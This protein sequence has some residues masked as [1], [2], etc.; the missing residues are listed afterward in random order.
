MKNSFLYFLI[1]FI[2]NLS[3]V[4]QEIEINSNKIRYDDI[5]KVTIFEGNV[6]SVDEEGNKFFSEYT[7]YNKLTEI[8]E[9]KGDTKVIT[10]SGYEVFTSDV[11]FNNKENIIY[12][13]NKSNIVDKDGN[14]IS[15]QMFNYSILT[16]IFFSKG[17]IKIKDIN[18]N[19]YNFSEIY[20]DENKKKIIGSDIKAFL[21]DPNLAINA[22]NDPKFFANTMSSTENTNTYEKGVFT[23][24]K[25]RVDDKCP[26]WT[27]QSK[28][29]THDI[30]KKT[31]YYDNVVLKVYDF[32]IFWAP[33]FSH[34]DPTVKRR[35]G[36]LAPSLSNHSNLGSGI[37][38]PYFWNIAKDKDLTFTPKIYINENPL[39]LA[40][41]RQDFV[42]SFLIVDAGYTQGYKNN[43]LK[44][45]EGGRA[46]F[47]SN[48]TTKFV[49]EKEKRSS[50]DINIEKV[51]NDTYFKIYDVKSILVNKDKVV[52]ENKF[53][54]IYQNKDFF[55]GLAP[56]VYEDTTKLGHLRHE[57][58]LPLTVEKNIMANQKYGLL[59]LG[60]NL[61]IKNYDTDKQLNT[62]INDFNWK[63]KKWLNYFG[64]E[65]HF[66]GLVKTVNYDAENTSDYK[67]EK[68]NSEAHSALGFF[69]KLPLYKEDFVNKNFHSLIPKF[70]LRYAPGHMR[71]IKGGK[72]NYGNLYSLNKVD[73]FDVVE[74]GLSTSV[75]F[76]YKKN[77]LN[78]SNKVGDD[79]VSLSIG[80]VISAEENMDIPS[81]TS[82][83]QRFSDIVG[84]ATYNVDKKLN[85][86]YNFSIDQGYR[87]FNYNDIGADFTYDKAKF[88]LNFLQEKNHIGNQK[89]VQTGVDFNLNNSSKL[90][91]GTK[92]NLLSSSAEFYNFSYNYINDCLKAGLAYRREFYTDRD[93]APSNSLMF[94][95][96]IIPFA[97]INS[98]LSK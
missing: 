25:N 83:E 93:I 14:N 61:R 40:E 62:F 65:S 8:I 4:A 36:L 2:F 48:F 71:S 56:A 79:I 92:R 19:S 24:C 55:F 42:N 41:Y 81:S 28:R 82:L 86:N 58:L 98:P 23:Y 69:A 72:L 39:L 88:N 70:F 96:S 78:E 17:N 34:P 29:I 85:L 60:S 87:K 15:V 30:P 75:G 38:A 32:P 77:K 63:S 43:T 49:N 97:N 46:H 33:K 7:K 67:N 47:F 57:Y 84:K 16:N 21:N 27:L 26:P 74:P 66:K 95:I 52:L 73:E 31:I 80:Q 18:N 54:F 94:T 89:Y 6:S 1:F 3:L 35:S 11:I 12:S 50:L 76:E 9:T 51:S 22:D 37:S 68:T 53:D 90:S 59:D 64:I 91:F 5:N 44:K 20:I 10:S 45:T 13:N